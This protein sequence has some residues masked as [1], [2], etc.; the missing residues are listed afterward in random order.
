[1]ADDRDARIAQL[2]AELRQAQAENAALRERAALL[3]SQVEQHDGARAEALEQQ[4]A[5]A[6][7]LRVI[8]ASPTDLQPVLD[9]IV[10]AALRLSHASS[11]SIARRRPRDGRLAVCAIAGRNASRVKEQFGPNYFDRLPGGEIT[12][13]MIQGRVLLEQRTIVVDD[14]LAAVEADFPESRGAQA[15]FGH[16]SLVSVPLMDQGDAIGVLTVARPEVRPFTTREVALLE[17]FADQAVIAIENARLFEALERRNAQLTSALDQ[18]TATAEVLRVIA[19]APT[20]LDRVL[21]AIVETAARLCEAPRGVLLQAR[22]RDGRLAPR[23]RFRHATVPVESNPVDFDSSPGVLP[24]PTSAVGHA[25]VEGRTIHVL[26]MAEAIQHEYPD[27]QGVRARIGLRTVVYVPLLRHGRS[28]GVLSMQKLEVLPFTEQQIRLLETFADQAVIAIENARLFDESERRNA[29]LQASNRQVTEALEQQT[30]TAEVLRVIASTPTD[31]QRVLQAVAGAARRLC[32]GDA[33]A[34]Q[35]PVGDRLPSFVIDPP[36]EELPLLQTEPLPTPGTINDGTSVISRA[37][38]DRRTVHVPNIDAVGE[39]FPQSLAIAHQRG[40][41]AQVAAPL[42][43]GDEAIG[44]LTLYSFEARPFTDRQ[45]ALLETFADQAAIAIANARLFEE[46][47]R[48]NRELG[49]ALERQTATSE[50]LRVIASSPTD[51][52]VVL[53]AV[54]KSAMRLCAANDAVIYR[55]DGDVMRYAAQ[56]RG[57]PY[58][59]FEGQQFGHGV[60]LSRDFVGGRA[61]VERRTIQVLDLLTDPD[62]PLGQQ[63]A[64]TAGHR[65]TLAIPLLREGAA[66]GALVLTHSTVRPFTD[67]QVALLETF[68]DQAVIAIENARLF[69][70]LERRNRELSEALTHQTALG[71][72]LRVIAPAP[73]DLDR[74]LQEIVGTAARLCDA[75]GAALLQFRERDGRLAARA[76]FGRTR[77]VAEGDNIDF[78]AD[79]GVVPTRAS[80]PGHAY[81][82]GRTIRSPTWLRP[83]D[84]GIPARAI[85]RPSSGFARSSSCRCSAKMSASACSRC[86]ASR[87]SPLPRARSGS[88]RRSPTR[89]SSPSRMPGSSRSCTIV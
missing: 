18:Q 32:G 80:G 73:T 3:V 44:I 56:G 33:S 64:A 82:A 51:A 9:V 27:S 7:V 19:S 65:T 87:S 12:P 15:I 49:E 26:D 86:N 59:F 47:E 25:H 63:M 55:L 74:V 76:R 40:W 14:L 83:P 58:G 52:Q 79:R 68:A 69:E 13:Q 57:R 35:R 8:A 21:D 28:I 16:R 88:W 77:E 72:V 61:V 4:I 62:F 11:A 48:R 1:M 31:L 37:F 5:L 39:Q 81:L 50:I 20:D 75:P 85:S 67:E 60:P 23:A 54:A 29:E 84:P 38:L 43:R 6:E 78:Q 71:E 45:I 22:E 36:M 66:T 46:L 34:V 70:E 17:T 42:L 2:E 30:A 24:A 89:P 41:R 10:G 53:D